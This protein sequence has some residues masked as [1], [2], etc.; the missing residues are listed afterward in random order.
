MIDGSKNARVDRETPSS[1]VDRLTAGLRALAQSKRDSVPRQVGYSEVPQ[2]AGRIDMLAG[3]VASLP[4]WDARLYALM[5]TAGVTRD[6][7]TPGEWRAGQE[8]QRVLS[9]LGANSEFD[10]DYALTELTAAGVED[11]IA[12]ERTERIAAESERNRM[13]AEHA[14]LSELRA[15]YES[16]RQRWGI[17]ASAHER[18]LA[19]AARDARNEV[20]RLAQEHAESNKLD[21]SDSSLELPQGVR[22]HGAGFQATARVGGK[23]RQKTFPTVELAAAQVEQWRDERERVAA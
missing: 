2:I 4:L 13:A 20:L 16:A 9:S 15:I 19:A 11:A 17:G 5:V 7:L 3:Y 10:V 18:D 6:P 22:R 21:S 1:F 8:Q 23:Q 14:D 12:V